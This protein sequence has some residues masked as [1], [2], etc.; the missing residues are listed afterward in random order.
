MAAVRGSDEGSTRSMARKVPKA[1][2]ET[3]AELALYARV[4]LATARLGMEPKGLCPCQQS[5]EGKTV[6]VTG[7]SS[8]IGRATATELARRGARV[9]IA[10]RNV[11]KATRVAQEILRETERP[12]VVKQLDLCSLASVRRFCADLAATEPRLDVLINNA[13]SVGE[14][15]KPKMT[16]D[17]FEVTFQ[18]NY[19][20]PIL[21]TLLLQELLKKTAPSRVV[22]VS[23]SFHVF[24][25]VD[26][27]EER[28]RGHNRPR[29]PTGIY[30]NTKLALNLA[31]L[32][33]AQRLR[34]SGVTV[35]CLHPGGVRTS[36][37]DG[38]SALRKYLFKAS[39]DLIGKTPLEG[40]QTSIWLAVDPAM[41]ETTGQYFADCAPATPS[42]DCEDHQ[43]AEDVFWRSVRMLPLT[44]SELET[45]VARPLPEVAV[46]EQS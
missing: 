32:A 41:V 28:A 17:G 44:D 10:C 15:K 7:A 27:L 9:I 26:S 4:A 45:L 13:G 38:G 20:G 33:L 39:M 37:S 1:L 40:A 6:V 19:L 30:A 21:L 42:K 2:R 29:S 23:S 34:H 16:E 8:G 24:G 11:A 5:M 46:L 36:I 43:L 31:T 3:F 18:S 35:N 25:R 22:N 12:V 14:S